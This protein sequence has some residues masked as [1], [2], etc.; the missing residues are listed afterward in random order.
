MIKI[1]EVTTKR[2]FNSFFKFPY[3]LF[4]N[5]KMWVPQ[6]L[7]SEKGTFNVK[8]NPAFEHCKAK[9]FLAYKENKIVGR[10]AGIINFKVNDFWKQK[11]IR[12]GWLDFIDD[13]EVAEQLLNAVENWGKMEG[14]NEIIGPMGFSNLDRAGMTVDGFDVDTP[15]A[16]YYNP[17]YYPKIMEKIGYGKAVDTIQYL[18]QGSQPVPENILRINNWIKDKYKLKIVEGISKKELVKRYGMKL[19]EALNQTH[20][21]L[22]EFAPLTEKQM[23]YAIKENFSFLD[24]KLICFIVDEHD[25][26]VGFGISMP[27]FTNALRK[28]KGKIF[29]FGWIYLLKALKNYDTIDLLLTGVLPEWQNKGVHSLY[30]AALNNSFISLGVK[31][32]FSSPSLEDNDV[33]RVWKNYDGKFAMRKRTYSKKLD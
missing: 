19:F 17:E 5:D 22:F 10:V 33:R 6:L 21:K 7:T 24:L 16:C 4:K 31:N 23:H 12:F 20:A 2:E 26:I 15:M 27:S 11:K 28:C 32:A 1:K 18:L 30:H 14:M 13:Q 29:P 9:L 3:T 8:K 25:D